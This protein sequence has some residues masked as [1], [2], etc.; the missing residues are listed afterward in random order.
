[1]IDCIAMDITSSR[2]TVPSLPEVTGWLYCAK[3]ALVISPYAKQMF[4]NFPIARLTYSHANLSRLSPITTRNFI[5]CFRSIRF[6]FSILSYYV[7][8][9]IQ[10]HS[11]FEII[12]VNFNSTDKEIEN[13]FKKTKIIYKN[14]FFVC[15]NKFSDTCYNIIDNFITPIFCSN[16][17]FL[18]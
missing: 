6:F 8:R 5:Q 15:I 7:S 10:K 18:K 13:Y 11:A 17:I 2:Q 1:M 9:Q 4:R 16:V 3:V 14:Y 12:C